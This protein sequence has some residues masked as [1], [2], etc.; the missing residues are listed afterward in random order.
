MNALRSYAAGNMDIE[1]ALAYV[2][3]YGEEFSGKVR[4]EDYRDTLRDR[5]WENCPCQVCRE[6]GIEVI[7]L[8]VFAVSLVL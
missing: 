5:P 3:R 2:V 6:A 7:I 1:E 4:I 8:L